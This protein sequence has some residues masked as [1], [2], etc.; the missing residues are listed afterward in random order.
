MVDH[1]RFLVVLAV[2]SADQTGEHTV[3]YVGEVRFV[4]DRRA[5]LS[6]EAEDDSALGLLDPFETVKVLAKLFA[7]VISTDCIGGGNHGVWFLWV[8][9]ILLEPPLCLF[10][11]WGNPIV[12]GVPRTIV[13]VVLRFGTPRHSELETTTS[14]DDE[15]RLEVPDLVQINPVVA[16]LPLQRF[17]GVPTLQ[18]KSV[19]AIIAL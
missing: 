4:D 11:P 1:H 3:V 8:L 17:T 7:M 19:A 2:A 14:S 16:H 10:D 9:F 12:T 6:Q 15:T 5:E 18:L 13:V